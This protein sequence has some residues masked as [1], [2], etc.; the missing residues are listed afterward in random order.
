MKY[1]CTIL[2]KEKI[3]HPRKVKKTWIEVWF[4]PFFFFFENGEADFRIS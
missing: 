2:F 1:H 4:L 3:I